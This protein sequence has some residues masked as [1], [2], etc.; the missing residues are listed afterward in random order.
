MFKFEDNNAPDYIYIRKNDEKLQY[1]HKVTK[2][3]F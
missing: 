1:L 2:K 3:S